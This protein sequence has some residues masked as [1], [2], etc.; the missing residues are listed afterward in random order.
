[1]DLALQALHARSAPRVL[2]LGCGSGALA[3][4]IAAQRGDAE[5]LAIVCCEGALL[6]ACA[7]AERLQLPVILRHGQWYAA[8]AGES[9]DVIVCNPPYVALEDAELAAEVRRY[10]PGL[11]L[12]AGADGLA[13]LRTVIAGASAHLRR[14]GLLLVEHGARQGAGR[15]QPVRGRGF[16][17][18]VHRERRRRA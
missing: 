7:N 12:F 17:G 8:V 1:M 9:F 13:A 5:V 10:E 2:D 18:G 3:L 16:A 6:V 14:D 4:A 15:A 11:A